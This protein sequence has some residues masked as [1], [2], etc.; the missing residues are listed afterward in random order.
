MCLVPAW[1][2]ATAF[3]SMHEFRSNRGYGRTIGAELISIRSELL[4]S[5]AQCDTMVLYVQWIVLGVPACASRHSA[6]MLLTQR[7]LNNTLY[8]KRDT[9]VSREAGLSFLI[10]LLR[11]DGMR[12]APYRCVGSRGDCGRGVLCARVLRPRR[13][14]RAGLVLSFC[15]AFINYYIIM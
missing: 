9:Q 4:D 7:H 5:N 15:N 1:P 2:F 13:S 8:S 10:K 12:W 14:G 3:C 11:W 6:I